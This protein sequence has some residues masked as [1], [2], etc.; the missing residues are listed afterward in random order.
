M[1]ERGSDIRAFSRA[2]PAL[3]KVD[4][5]RIGREE[6][7]FRRVCGEVLGIFGMSMSQDSVQKELC[8]S[9]PMHRLAAAIAPDCPRCRIVCSTTKQGTSLAFKGP[10]AQTEIDQ[11]A[12][13]LRKHSLRA[14]SSSAMNRRM[15]SGRGTISSTYDAHSRWGYCNTD[16]CTE[17]FPRPIHPQSGCVRRLGSIDATRIRIPSARQAHDS[18]RR[19]RNLHASSELSSMNSMR[20]CRAFRC[21]RTYQSSGD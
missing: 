20:N 9:C 4:I 17:R 14:W 19:N 12:A 16:R 7:A 10:D 13:E 2:H 3:G 5:V 8:A 1:P 6:S 21:G 18:C 11:A 15:D